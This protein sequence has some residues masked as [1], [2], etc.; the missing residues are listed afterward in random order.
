MRKSAIEKRQEELEKY[1]DS[2]DRKTFLSTDI[3]KIYDHL[4]YEWKL[5]QRITYN[6]FL[7][8]L[9]HIGLVDT[10]FKTPTGSKIVFSWKTDHD[11]TV[12]SGIK[13]RSY[14]SHLSAMFIN[15]LTL[16]IPKTYYLNHEHSTTF[17]KGELSQSAID[18]AFSKDQRKSN[19]IYS[20]LGKKVIVV[21]GKKTNRL[22]VIDKKEEDIQYSYTDLERTLID[23]AIRPAYSGGVFEVS[24]VYF[25]VKDKVDIDK[26]LSYLKKL[27]YLY[28]YHQVIGFYMELASYPETALE[29]LSRNIDYDFYLT[30]NIRNKNYSDRW[31]L[32]FPKGLELLG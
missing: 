9:L 29:K 20:N 8:L 22:G 16:Q 3:R 13:P 18:S 7:S 19:D 21:N 28:P 12:M 27:D 1:F 10:T 14:F 31:R 32:Y 26:L 25:D 4:S 5:P 23:I 24:N 15:Q 2:L 17:P 11:L 6:K 30:Y